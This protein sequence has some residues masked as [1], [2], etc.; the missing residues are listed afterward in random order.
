[1]TLRTNPLSNEREPNPAGT[2]DM[3]RFTPWAFMR[4]RWLTILISIICCTGIFGMCAI[5]GVSAQGAAMVAI[6]AGLCWAGALV[7][8]YARN[9]RFWHL[10]AVRTSEMQRS[11]EA[12]SLLPDAT[13][14]ESR[15]ASEA[16]ESTDRITARELT[17]AQKDAAEYREYVEIWIH[18]AKTPIAAAKLICAR[19]DAPEVDALSRE[20]ERVDNQVEQALYYARSTSVHKDYTIKSVPLVD[21]IRE[22][23]K[24]QARFL[25]ERQAIPHIDVSEKLEVLADEPW[26]IFM[27]GQVLA[28]AAQYGARTITFTAYE[29]MPNTPHGRT[30]LEVRDD[31]CG[32]DAADVPRV[33][34]RGFTGANGRRSGTATGMGLYLVALMCMQLGLHVSL[35]SEEGVGT[36]VLFSFPHDRSRL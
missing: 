33:F 3:T 19:M 2:E 1:M 25:I 28:N 32:I 17:D 4:D 34:D 31:G 20:L 21:A 36:R 23:C 11:D 35:A 6:F 15:I 12:M 9:A 5:Q 29:E 22:A 7:A 18:E 8:D 24:R 26:L 30:V 10:L 16:I 13:C 27:L 14:L